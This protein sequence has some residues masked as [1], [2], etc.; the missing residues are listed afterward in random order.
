MELRVDIEPNCEGTT[1][2]AWY[3]T[4]PCPDCQGCKGYQCLEDSK[5]HCG[6]NGYLISFGLTYCN[7]FN[8]K[9]T[10]KN[11]LCSNLDYYNKFTAAGQAFIDCVRPRLLGYLENYLNVKLKTY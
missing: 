6:P 11:Q 4:L 10:L 5:A 2:T 8:G 3:F 7:R 1:G 9:C